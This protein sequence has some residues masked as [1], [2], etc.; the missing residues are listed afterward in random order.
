MA[1][2]MLAFVV[3]P[4]EGPPTGGT[5]YNRRLV[6]ALRQRGAAPQVLTLAQAR[7]AVTQDRAATLWVDSLWMEA[8]PAL[9]AAAAAP[10]RVGLLTHYL[11]VLVS[12]G[13]AP[14]PSR[15]SPPERAALQ[16][17]HGLLA[18]SDYLAKELRALG[19]EDERVRVLEPGNEL[20]IEPRPAPDPSAGPLRAVVIANVT[21]GKGVEPLLEHLARHL[22]PSDGLELEVVGS[23][24]M[25]PAC[26]RRC[27]A[28]V[29]DRPAL[30]GRVRL[31]GARPHRTCIEALL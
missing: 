3:P 22:A 27:V 23:L 2:R 16:H 8:L 25:E 12:H 9:A 13:E 20:P 11:P 7:E 10:C 4:L 14:D 24:E 29:E 15:L 6:A 18:P 30:R 5:R 1:R 26:A 21:E 19:V 17:A 31:G 28:L